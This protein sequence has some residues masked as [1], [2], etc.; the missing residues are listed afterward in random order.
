MKLNE[1][2]KSRENSFLDSIIRQKTQKLKHENSP[3]IVD[4]FETDSDE[5]S[6]Q[7]F[8]LEKKIEQFTGFGLKLK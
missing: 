1:V 6:D 7:D 2:M 8:L 3:V 4:D 5:E